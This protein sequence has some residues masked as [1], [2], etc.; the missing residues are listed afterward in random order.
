LETDEVDAGSV[1]AETIDSRDGYDDLTSSRSLGTWYQNTTGGDQDISVAVNC[2]SDNQI[3]HISLDISETQTQN[4]VDQIIENPSDD[5][6]RITVNGT[7]PD[8]FYY[9]VVNN[10]GATASLRRWVEQ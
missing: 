5:G 8:G 2:D 1:N 4:R 6:T 3:F 9:R 10:A 7:V